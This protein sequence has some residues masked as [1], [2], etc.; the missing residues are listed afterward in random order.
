MQLWNLPRFT[1][2]GNRLGIFLD[3]DMSFEKTSLMT[4]E[5]IL[6]NI[7]IR[8]GLEF[9]LEIETSSGSFIQLLDYEGVPFQ[10]HRC[11]TLDHLVAQCTFPFRGMMGGGKTMEK[12]G[13]SDQQGQGEYLPSQSKSG[14]VSGGIPEVAK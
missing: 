5:R 11:H 14:L 4:M 1:S 9:E 8:Q 2:I 12:G 6:V 10:C 13:L 3:V 7:D